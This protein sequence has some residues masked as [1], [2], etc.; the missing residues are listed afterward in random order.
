M[1]TALATV[2]SSMLSSPP[3]PWA[4]QRSGTH[5][6]ELH[7]TSTFDATKQ[8]LTSHRHA[9]RCAPIFTGRLFK[10]RR[11]RFRV[12]AE[13]G[14][15][16]LDGERLHSLLPGRRDEASQSRDRR[17]GAA[18]RDFLHGGGRSLRRCLARA[19]RLSAWRTLPL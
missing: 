8:E 2:S 16:H 19:G 11:A 15:G 17:L 10:G 4:S 1:S 9:R 7:R 5:I 18:V 3:I 14:L 13:T 6:R 12:V